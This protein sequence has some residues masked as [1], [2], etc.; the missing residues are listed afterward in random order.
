MATTYPIN[1]NKK[2]K[3]ESTDKAIKSAD[4]GSKAVQFLILIGLKPN[5]EQVR[6][7]KQQLRMKQARVGNHYSR[8]QLEYDDSMKLPNQAISLL[9]GLGPEPILT[10]QWV[11]NLE[12]LLVTTQDPARVLNCYKRRLEKL[13]LIERS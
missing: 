3:A 11:K 9:S 12:G 1:K 8:T 13:G 5:E 4:L 2:V 6:K 10:S 7:I